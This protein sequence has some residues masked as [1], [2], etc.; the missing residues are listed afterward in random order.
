M[1]PVE[2]PQ[3][4][5][6]LANVEMNAS[7]T[8]PVRLVRLGQSSLPAASLVPSS[9]LITTR[10]RKASLVLCQSYT[11]SYWLDIFLDH[12]VTGH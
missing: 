6:N 3:R 4:V 12:T 11:Y 2:P 8:E 5:Q 9:E 10:V 1:L 7:S